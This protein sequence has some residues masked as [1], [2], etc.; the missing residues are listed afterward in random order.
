MAQADQGQPSF[1]LR[2]TFGRATSRRSGAD[3]N[4]TPQ[5]AAIPLVPKLPDNPA[6]T[7]LETGLGLTPGAPFPL[8]SDGTYRIPAALIDQNMVRELNA[9]TFPKP[10]Y[11]VHGIGLQ[12]VHRFRQ[13]AREHPRRCGPHRSCHQQQ[14]PVDGTLP[15]RRYGQHAI[16]RRCGAPASQASAPR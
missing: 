6:Y 7:A 11:N 3:L 4:Y 16:S 15:S 1:A 2:T 9:G 14:I 10:N 5:S 12:T 13:A 8:N